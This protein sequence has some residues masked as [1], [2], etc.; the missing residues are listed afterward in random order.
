MIRSSI[1]LPPATR[2]PAA[3]A[4]NPRLDRHQLRERGRRG[5]GDE[6]PDT[7]LPA[8]TWFALSPSTR[9]AGA[10]RQVWT[11]SGEN[12]LGAKREGVRH[13]VMDISRPEPAVTA[14]QSP[15]P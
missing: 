11:L 3:H 13:L 6:V 12:E 4:Q 8:G 7:S 5:A 1:A 10:V 9:A 2:A 14:R 15:R